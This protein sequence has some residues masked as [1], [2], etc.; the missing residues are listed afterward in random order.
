MKIQRFQAPDMRAA[1]KLVREAQG[2]QA[3]ILSSQRSSDGVEVVA[4]VDYDES[5]V[6]HALGDAAK[7]PSVPVVPTVPSSPTAAADPAGARCAAEAVA[8]AAA[9]PPIPA[10]A[11]RRSTIPPQAMPLE[12]LRHDRPGHAEFLSLAEPEPV[13]APSPQ[14][15]AVPALDLVVDS[16]PDDPAVNEMRRELGEMRAMIEREMARFTD[17]RLRASPVRASLIDELDSYGCDP[18][19]TRSITSQVP[20]DAERGRA[21]GIALGLLAKSIVIPS[22]EPIDEGGVMALVGPPGAGKTTTIAKLAARFAAQWSP[23]DVALVT[24]DTMRV[25]ARD[26]LQHYGRMLGMP[27]IEV[28]RDADLGEQLERLADYRLVLVDTAG[29]S[30]RDRSLATHFQWLNAARRMR[31]YLVLPANGQAEDL[32]EIVQRFRGADPEGVILSKVDETSRLGTALSVVIRQRMPL[33]YVADGQRVPEDLQVAE[34]H[35]LVLRLN[36][37]RRATSETAHTEHTHAVA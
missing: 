15:P 35:R 27:V 20:L 36:D 26:Q 19:L 2:P 1:L 5:L 21:R 25:G 37:L 30:H 10:T 6:R 34:G 24:T 8:E 31:S 18:E 28:T 14:G 4:A 12:P 17:E 11:K 9:T 22:P 33:A 3:V 23:R 29:I 16:R 13:A 32:D 7:T